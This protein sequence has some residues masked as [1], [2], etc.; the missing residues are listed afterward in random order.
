MSRTKVGLALAGLLLIALLASAPA[1]LLTYFV[2]TDQV[3][4]QGVSGSLWK[5]RAGSCL[6]RVTG[7]YLHLGEVRWQLAPLSLL[8]LAPQLELDAR[9]GAQQLSGEIT[10]KGADSVR[11]RDIDAQLPASLLQQFLPVSLEGTLTAQFAELSLTEG[12]PVE[13]E[14]RVVW[15]GALWNSPLG[16]L[17]LGSYAMD[18]SQARDEPLRGEV[19][20]LAGPVSAEGE[21][22]IDGRRYRIDAL[23]SA[24][25]EGGLDPQLRQAL[26]LVAVPEGDGFRAR[27]DAEF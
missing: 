15:Q 4:L 21:A 25:D 11:L 7:G 14:G 9:W 24:E 22:E 27:L 17:A 10:L 2:P 18:I 19:L 20:T 6:L 16:R 3:L 1:R 8:L 23:I 13:A 12:L 5:G 26:S